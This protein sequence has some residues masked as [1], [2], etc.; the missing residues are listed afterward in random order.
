MQNGMIERKEPEFI[1]F[2][3]GDV[4][5]GA[6]VA[7]DRVDVRDRETGRVRPVVRYTLA[8]GDLMDDGSFRANGEKMSFLGSYHLNSLLETRDRGHYLAVK[9]LGLD[10]TV[11]RN[12][13]SM[14]RFQV[15]VS[16]R[17]VIGAARPAQANPEITD[18]DI[19]F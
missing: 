17:P 4:H 16:E 8:A 19:S 15:W 18:E 11:Q 9:F 2:K 6:L 13:N 7:I 14:K 12:G 1:E 5:Q 3:E 10:S